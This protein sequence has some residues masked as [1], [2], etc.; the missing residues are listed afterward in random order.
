MRPL[1]TLLAD[2]HSDIKA[3][4]RLLPGTARAKLD[5]AGVKA[6][7]QADPKATGA[8]LKVTLPAGTTKR[9]ARF[10]DAEGQDQC[11]AFFVTVRK[12]TP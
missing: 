5:I 8:T 3:A 4:M 1:P 10:A 9:K 7:T 12:W 11:G 2:R 6:E